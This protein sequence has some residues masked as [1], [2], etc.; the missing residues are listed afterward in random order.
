MKRNKLCHTGRK[1]RLL[2]LDFLVNSRPNPF[3]ECVKCYLRIACSQRLRS[4]T[5]IDI[6]SQGGEISS[7]LLLVLRNANTALSKRQWQALQTPRADM[8]CFAPITCKVHHGELPTEDPVSLLLIIQHRGD[9]WRFATIRGM[10]TTARAT[11]RC[12][13]VIA[14]PIGYHRKKI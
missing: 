11:V 4:H 7:L 1:T 10:I 6:L 5:H 8:A 14:K 12:F 2:N 3:P 13:V 9:M